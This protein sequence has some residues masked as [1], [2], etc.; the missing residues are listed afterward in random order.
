MRL[1]TK[2]R[3]AVTAML[4]LA[5]HAQQ[6][7]VSLADISLSY[8]E[9]LFSKL[10]RSEL[11]SSVRGPGGGYRLS[12]EMAEI[13]VAQII[14]AV[15]EQVDVTN[16]GGQADCQ[17]GNVCLTHHLWADLSSRIHSFLHDISLETLVSKPDVQNV[18]AR[19]DRIEV[20]RTA[21]VSSET[22]AV[23]QLG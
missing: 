11:V 15:N 14:D 7:P 23:S 13:N 8:L 19:Q 17:D 12:R 22:I 10:R 18:S 5:L 21:V 3:Y 9:Q 16:C 2:G 1:T 6:G 4:D 20:E